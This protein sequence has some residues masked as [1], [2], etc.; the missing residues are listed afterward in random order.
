MNKR[1]RDNLKN[2]YCHIHETWQGAD[3]GEDVLV[4]KQLSQHQLQWYLRMILS[5]LP[6]IKELEK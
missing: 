5:S 2:L 3:F 4:C 1:L 6:T